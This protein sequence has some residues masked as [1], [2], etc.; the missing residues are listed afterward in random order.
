MLAT[1]K[2]VPNCFAALTRVTRDLLIPSLLRIQEPSKQPQD[3][4]A[5]PV[6]VHLTDPHSA[7]GK[8]G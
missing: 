1:V 4:G 6:L 7:K 8:S 5:E 3:E 2:K